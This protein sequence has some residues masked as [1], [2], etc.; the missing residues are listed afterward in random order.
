MK[1]KLTLA[2]AAALCFIACLGAVLALARTGA[3]DQWYSLFPHPSGRY[4]HRAVLDR[5]NERMVLMGGAIFEVSYNDVWALDLSTVTWAQLFPSGDP[6]PA[7]RDPIAVFFAREEV[8]GIIVFGGN[9]YGDPYVY[10]DH[11]YALLLD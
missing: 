3:A 5:P 9:S 4:G 11:T 6:P 10:Y 2:R 7:C 1:A 8:K